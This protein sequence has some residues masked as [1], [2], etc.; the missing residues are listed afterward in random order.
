VSARI[1]APSGR[2]E[3]VRLLPEGEEWGVFHGRYVPQEPGG[4]QLTLA[5]RQTGATLDARFFVQG[6]DL[7]QVGKPARPEVLE[8]IA[9]VTRGAA[10]HATETDIDEIVGSLT[11]LPLPPPSVR[12]LQLWSHPLAAGL[13]IFLLGA[14]WVWRKT[15]GLI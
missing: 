7:E 3:T 6:G 14:F 4:H 10:Y 13:V 9:R 2:T 11:D 12:R 15:I 5:C 1:T 8:E